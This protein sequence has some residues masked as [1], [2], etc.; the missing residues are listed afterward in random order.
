MNIIITGGC[1][2]IGSA[3][4]RKL[5]KKNNHKI[6]NIDKLTYA[7]NKNVFTKNKKNYYFY[8]LDICNQNKIEKIFFK[9]KPDIIINLAAESHVDNSIK[10]SQQFIKTNIIG[11]YNL[12]EISRKYNQSLQSSKKLIFYQISTDEVYGD[13]GLSKKLFVEN[14]IYKPSSPYS[15]SKSSADH[16]VRSW[17]RTYK[18]PFFISHCTNNYGPYQNKE[19]LIPLVINNALKKLPIPIYGNG[20][21]VRDWIY[22]NDHVDAIYRIAIKGKIGESYN[23][24]GNNQ[25]S[26]LEV[27]S[28]ICKLLDKLVSKKTKSLNSYLDLITYVKDRKGHDFKYGLNTNKIKNKLLWKPKENF[29]TGIQKTI[30]WYLTNN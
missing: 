24:G 19:K 13:L 17:G 14:S 18:L 21:Q 22:V 8:K 11:T 15:A 4:L 9:F 27:V 23:I 3:L 29:I 20:K 5:F 16:L 30:K 2:F 28:T 26:N 12:L 25:I 1:G 6:V 7:S 10:N